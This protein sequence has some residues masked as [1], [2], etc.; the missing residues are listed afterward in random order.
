MF[1]TGSSSKVPFDL[2]KSHPAACKCCNRHQKFGPIFIVFIWFYMPFGMRLH[3]VSNFHGATRIVAM[4]QPKVAANAFSTMDQ[5]QE[6]SKHVCWCRAKS[7][8]KRGRLDFSHSRGTLRTG[9]CQDMSWNVV[10]H[11]SLTKVSWSNP[12]GNN[13]KTA[14][15]ELFVILMEPIF[16]TTVL[17]STVLL[18]P[19][20]LWKNTWISLLHQPQVIAP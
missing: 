1:S 4:C 9:G 2:R 3:A 7:L 5:P 10:P 18:G 17:W 13:E 14:G 16:E 20:V 19:S 8:S 15:M 12:S 11:I 6:F